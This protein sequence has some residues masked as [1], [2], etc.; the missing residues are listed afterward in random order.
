VHKLTDNLNTLDDKVLRDMK[1]ANARNSYSNL[2]DSVVSYL[3]CTREVH[4]S[5]LDRMTKLTEGSVI[6][7]IPS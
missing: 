4:S 1:H 3:A 7:H 6:F 5:Y 2:L